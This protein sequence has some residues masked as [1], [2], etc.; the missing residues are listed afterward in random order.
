MSTVVN[1]LNLIVRSEENT[2]I[3]FL[4]ENGLIQ[5]D[6]LLL[7]DTTTLKKNRI[8]SFGEL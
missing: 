4:S 2:I 1:N 8:L 6:A 3:R 5:I 7:V